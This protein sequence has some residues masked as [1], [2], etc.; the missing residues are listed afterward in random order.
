MLLLWGMGGGLQLL[1]EEHA[2][3]PGSFLPHVFHSMQLGAFPIPIFHFI[4]P[5]GF[6]L[7]MLSS[8]QPGDFPSPMFH[9]IQPGA[10]LPLMLPFT[11]PFMQ[12]LNNAPAVLVFSWLGTLPCPSQICSW[13]AARLL[14]QPLQGKHGQGGGGHAPA[15]KK[16]HSLL[17]LVAAPGGRL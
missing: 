3:L 6:L 10:L 14:Q 11:L 2:L 12:P 9:F 4:Q 16:V 7:L 15:C 5:G 17:L 1:Q 8:M 13:P